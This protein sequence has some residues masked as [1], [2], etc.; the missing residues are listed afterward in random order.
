MGGA[1]V[2]MHAMFGNYTSGSYI[3]AML[4]HHSPTVNKNILPWNRDDG[5]LSYAAAVYRWKERVLGLPL[6]EVQNRLW[7]ISEKAVGID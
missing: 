7:E 6:V 5:T 1:G 4:M 2:L 3:D